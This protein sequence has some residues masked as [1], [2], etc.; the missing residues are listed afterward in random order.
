MRLSLLL[1]ASLLA[2]SS[3]VAATPASDQHG[4]HAHALAHRADD[5]DQGDDNQDARPRRHIPKKP[6]KKH[7]VKKKKKLPAKRKSKASASLKL[8]KCREEL[9]ANYPSYEN[10]QSAIEI[11][12]KA[13]ALI[14]EELVATEQEH[15]EKQ[16]DIILALQ[17]A[18]TYLKMV[19]LEALDDTLRW[20]KT[21]VLG[22][23]AWLQT[24]ISLA[25]RLV[26]RVKPM[27]RLKWLEK[28]AGGIQKGLSWLWGTMDK[29]A[30][31]KKKGMTSEEKQAT[32]GV[33][34]WVSN[35]VISIVG[36]DNK[37]TTELCS[38]LVD[39]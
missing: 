10:M 19:Q 14:P 2:L 24:K 30:E 7:V 6:V 35:A 34:Q 32:K 11:Y 12:K 17:S 27:P 13:L 23:A 33:N 1:F 21:L 22:N 31:T 25:E 18:S 15:K 3:F 9:M 36:A 29:L 26:Q 28:I 8:K 39:E 4:H 37:L 5:D 38:K 20:R 16:D